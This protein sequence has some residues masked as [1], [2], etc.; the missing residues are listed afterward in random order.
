LILNYAADPLKIWRLDGLFPALADKIKL[1][2]DDKIEMR[3]LAEEA[4]KEGYSKYADTIEYFR[5][6]LWNYRAFPRERWRKDSDYL[7]I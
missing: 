5:F 1:A 3:N 4:K 6:S 7:K 2:L